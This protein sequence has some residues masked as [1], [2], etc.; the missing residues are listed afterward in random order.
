MPE[1]HF[2]TQPVTIEYMCDTCGGLVTHQESAIK[3]VGTPDGLFRHVCQGCGR[4]YK[5]KIILPQMQH[6]KVAPIVPSQE[7]LNDEN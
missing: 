5:F 3:P 6:I 1:V 7:V 2:I 4:E